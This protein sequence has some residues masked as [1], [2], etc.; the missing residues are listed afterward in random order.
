MFKAY[1]DEK[2]K[3]F[4]NNVKVVTRSA[5]RRDVNING[6]YT[7][8]KIEL[9]DD[10]FLKLKTSIA[11]HGNEGSDRDVYILNDVFVRL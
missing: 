8:Y 4:L 3:P 10:R 6:S 9:N 11:P 7:G 5:I 1:S 2:R